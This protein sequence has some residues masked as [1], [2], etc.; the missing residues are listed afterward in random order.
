MPK[1][2]E[3][4]SAQVR[5][6]SRPEPPATATCH[7]QL[8]EPAD[9]A[10][11]RCG[12]P[13]TAPPPRGSA[14]RAACARPS[15]PRPACSTSARLT[16]LH[17]SPPSFQTP[18]APC[19]STP[20]RPPRRRTIFAAPHGA[21]AARSPRA[22]RPLVLDAEGRRV[23]ALKVGRP[24]SGDF[25]LVRGLEEGFGQHQGQAGFDLLADDPSPGQH[26][27]AATAPT[28]NAPLRRTVIVDGGEGLS[29][30]I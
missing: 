3:R 9:G 23:A 10:A 22:A 5:A 18:P 8:T 30:K 27:G 4:W 24:R 16:P 13:R 15:A 17:P 29:W 21:A 6:G 19:R 20:S 12:A 11:A 28:L 2:S 7:R 14:R 25:H 1:P 26:R